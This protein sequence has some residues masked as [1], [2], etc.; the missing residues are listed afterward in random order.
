MKHNLSS[1]YLYHYKQDINILNLILQNGFRFNYWEEEL[2]YENNFQNNFI[3]CFCDI[4]ITDAKHHRKIYGDNGIV[5][6]KE[7]GIKNGIT[8]IRYLHHNSPNSDGKYR[9]NKN[10]F[11]IASLHGQEYNS[12]SIILYLLLSLIKSEGSF[13]ESF[14]I[15]EITEVIQKS[16]DLD[17][18]Y[19]KYKELMTKLP[20]K[21]RN[22]VSKYLG[23][24]FTRICELH[25]Q[26]ELRDTYSRVY[27]SDNRCL[28]DER[29]W[30]ASPFITEQMLSED[31]NLFY[32]A[33][34]QRF[35]P[36][37]FNLSFTGDDVHAILVPSNEAKDIILN[38]VKNNKCQI[39]FESCKSK[40]KL[41]NEFKEI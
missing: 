33:T 7:W 28:Y 41:I 8:P 19:D 36:S 35:L 4:K 31:K 10:L 1:K 17:T 22:L 25:S 29:E 15:N 6:T 3:V 20:E 40:I 2:P 5:L 12:N 23:S 16:N 13:K 24:L 11:R 38:F 37:K 9:T 30:R 39:S 32:K 14:D 34:K 21:D 26:L 27:F 18:H